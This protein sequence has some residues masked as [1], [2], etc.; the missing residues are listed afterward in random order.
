MNNPVKIAFVA[1]L[2]RE[3]RPLV[4]AWRVVQRDFDS[5]HLKFYENDGTVLVCGGIG[6]QFA[7]RATEAAISLYSPQIIVSVGYAGAL[8]SQLR[9][10][11]VIEPRQVV[12][13]RD[14]TISETNRGKGLLVTYTS[15]ADI[16]QKRKLSWAYRAECV[17]ME[18]AAVAMGTAARGVPFAALKVVSDE[19]DFAVPSMG[20]FIAADGTFNSWGFALHCAPRPWLW[21]G[22][23]RLARN[24]RVA[25]KALCGA[26]SGF[27]A[28]FEGVPSLN[29][30]KKIDN[31]TREEHPT[32][33]PPI[34]RSRA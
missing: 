29:A 20:R 33:E 27:I 1:A 17:D 34:L 18:A 25:S 15:I 16:E 28:E 5:R 7:R 14:G 3:V 4:R 32:F 11:D 31:S 9:V 8:N 12:D 10:G 19:F 26:I 24:S 21:P 23:I 6:A 2:E 13:A 30:A 22:V